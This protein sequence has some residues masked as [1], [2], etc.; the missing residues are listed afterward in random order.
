MKKYIELETVHYV[1]VDGITL[2]LEKPRIEATDENLAKLDFYI[3]GGYLTIIEVKDEKDLKVY[4]IPEEEEIPKEYL[5]KEVVTAKR[6]ELT[7]EE[8][9]SMNKKQLIEACKE[10]GIKEAK[11]SMKVEELKTLLMEK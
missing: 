1:S 10:L 6:I 2:T 7:K 3:K 4:Q 11:P 9:E 5:V 8:I